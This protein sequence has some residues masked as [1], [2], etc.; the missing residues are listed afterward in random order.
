MLDANFFRQK[1]FAT[2]PKIGLFLRATIE[3][4]A[5]RWRVAAPQAP[6]RAGVDTFFPLSFKGKLPG[7]Q[8]AV[9]PRERQIDSLHKCVKFSLQVSFIQPTRVSMNAAIIIMNFLM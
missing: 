1:A 3:S 8:K 2:A 4:A 5:G 9:L 6:R 7:V